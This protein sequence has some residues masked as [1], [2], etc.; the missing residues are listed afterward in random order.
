[1]IIDNKI[2]NIYGILLALAWA[3]ALI[4][5]MI[6]ARNKELILNVFIV[7]FIFGMIGAKGLFFITNKHLGTLNG[8]AV[9]GGLILGILSSWVYCRYI[10]KVNFGVVLDLAVPSIA[11]AQGIGRIGCLLDGCCHGII[12][13]DKLYVMYTHSNKVMN[14]IHLVPTQLISSIFDFSLGILL[15]IL[16]KKI[17]TSG[18]LSCIYLI[19]YGIGRFLIEFYRGDLE[20]GWVGILS[21]SQFIS[22]IG[23]IIGT[24]IMARKS[25]RK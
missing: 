12:T 9:Y 7:S 5:S 23:I 18:N 15:L 16:S 24:A 25:K 13:T 4:L 22:I 21:T 19:A 2:T 1:M 11:I 14:G 6:R 8:F 10:R 17:K 20:R 3:S